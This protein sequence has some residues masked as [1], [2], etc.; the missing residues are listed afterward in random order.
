LLY[1]L[2]IVL[3]RIVGRSRERE[4]ANAGTA[5][6]VLL[7]LL[8]VAVPARGQAV[9]QQPRPAPGQIPSDTARAPVPGAG[10][11]IDTSAARRMG[12]PSAPSHPLAAPDS[13]IE[14]LLKRKGFQATRFA[15]DSVTFHADTRRI[16]LSGQAR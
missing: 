14:S 4:A 3:A 2:G 8:G 16:D 5:S 13:T 11:P 1:E 10:Q 9:G 6:L 15:A 7:V 12:L